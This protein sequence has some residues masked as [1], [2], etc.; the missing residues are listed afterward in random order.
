MDCEISKTWRSSRPHLAVGLQTFYHHLLL[1][2]V[3]PKV[4]EDPFLIWIVLTDPFQASLDPTLDVGRIESQTKVE[5]LSIVSMVV[6]D[7]GPA[8]EGLV[9]SPT[10]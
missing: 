7:G 3:L 2:L 6:A 9:S 4:S 8:R 10:G 5:D 1:G